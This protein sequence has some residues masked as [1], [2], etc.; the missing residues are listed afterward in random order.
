MGFFSQPIN[1]FVPTPQFGLVLKYFL[2]VFLSHTY[3]YL[4]HLGISSFAQLRVSL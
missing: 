2:S 1:V 3:N 4:G